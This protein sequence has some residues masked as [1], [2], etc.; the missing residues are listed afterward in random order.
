MTDGRLRGKVTVEGPEATN[1]RLMVLLVE[2]GVLFPGRSTVVVHRLVARA[3]LTPS[4]EGEPWEPADGKMEFTFDRA[5]S[6]IDATNESHLD[7]L[8]RR[9]AGT[10]EKVSMQIDP[11][12]VSIL[13]YL[14]D[15]GSKRVLQAVQV[16]PKGAEPKDPEEE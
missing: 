12:Q 14:R 4:L 1:V 5:L 8:A 16:I 7:G 11:G 9:G 2:R 10:L 15:A 6:E 3:A 13:A